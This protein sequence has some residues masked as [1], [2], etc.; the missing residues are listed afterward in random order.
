V[1]GRELEVAREKLDKGGIMEAAG[2]VAD[3]VNHR[4]ISK[5]RGAAMH[6]CESV[7]P[8]DHVVGLGGQAV[9]QTWLGDYVEELARWAMGDPGSVPL[10]ITQ[11]LAFER[12]PVV[13]SQCL[14]WAMSKRVSTDGKLRSLAGAG[15]G[16]AP[17]YPFG[18]ECG[19]VETLTMDM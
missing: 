4:A 12:L 19:V 17:S 6:G 14:Q 1:Q 18:R 2:A 3:M 8:N 7:V 9:R 5:V 13:S 11:C 16:G 15:D 10:F